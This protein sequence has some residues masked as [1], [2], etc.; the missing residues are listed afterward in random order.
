LSQTR[1]Y[2][3]IQILCHQ[4]NLTPHF[5]F[6]DLQNQVEYLKKV[7]EHTKREHERYARRVLD[8]ASMVPRQLAGA[9]PMYTT[10]VRAQALPQ[11]FETEVIIKFSQCTVFMNLTFCMHAHSQDLP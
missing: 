11:N 6:I 3:A 9:D 8:A 1:K 2:Y 10:P 4:L 7:L 5:H